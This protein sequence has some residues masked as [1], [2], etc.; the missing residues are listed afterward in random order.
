[1][2]FLNNSHDIGLTGRKFFFKGVG[3]GV[4]VIVPLYITIPSYFMI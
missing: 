4:T 3:G 2:L 1:M